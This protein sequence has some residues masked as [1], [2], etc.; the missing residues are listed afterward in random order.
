MLV[1][2]VSVSLFYFG[3]MNEQ[4][5]LNHMTSIELDIPG[6]FDLLLFESYHLT[7]QQVSWKGLTWFLVSLGFR[8]SIC[9]SIFG[10]LFVLILCQLSPAQICYPPKYTESS[11]PWKETGKCLYSDSLTKPHIW[12]GDLWPLIYMTVAVVYFANGNWDE[13]I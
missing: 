7:S 6:Q 1:Y 3:D 5:K 13:N 10:P 9:G 4:Y 8:V 11:V 12:P 2:L